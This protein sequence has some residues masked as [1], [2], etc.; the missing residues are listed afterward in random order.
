M[1]MKTVA[2]LHA[3]WMRDDPEYRA[4]YEA[5]AD[6]FPETEPQER[7]TAYVISHKADQREETPE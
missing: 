1:A 2:E 6:E 4:A 5:L 7:P 3:R